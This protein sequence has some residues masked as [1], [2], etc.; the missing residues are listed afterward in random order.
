MSVKPIVGSCIVF[1]SSPST[2]PVQIPAHCWH[3]GEGKSAFLCSQAS[4][5]W[6]LSVTLCVPGARRPCVTAQLEEHSVLDTCMYFSLVDLYHGHRR[7]QDCTICAVCLC[8][9]CDC[10]SYLLGQTSLFEYIYCVCACWG[11]TLSLAASWTWGHS[12]SAVPTVHGISQC[13]AST[14]CANAKMKMKRANN[15]LI[16]MIKKILIIIF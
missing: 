8:V 9:E 6:Q 7:E 4:S 16:K 10:Q 1:P 5:S 12:T 15:R 11:C 2:T 3:L 14:L 13:T